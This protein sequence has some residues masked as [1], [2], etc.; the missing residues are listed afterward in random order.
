M[1]FKNRPRIICSLVNHVRRNAAKRDLQTAAPGCARLSRIGT[2]IEI[3]ESR[4]GWTLYE[5]AKQSWRG[6]FVAWSYS[7]WE[8][9]AQISVS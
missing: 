4:I 1:R 9:K 3:N 7:Y 8:F 2:N 6:A 5:W